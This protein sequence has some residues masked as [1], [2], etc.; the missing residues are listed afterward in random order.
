[1][2][3]D[4]A[5]P[6]AFDMTLTNVPSSMG[7]SFS[8]LPVRPAGGAWSSVRDFAKFVRLELAKGRLPDGSTYFPEEI[9]LERRKPQVRVREE[10]WY[11]MGLWIK[12][13][14]GI[15]V[16][17]HGG[18]LF[19]YQSDFF[20]VPELGLGGVVLT[21]ADTGYFVADAVKKR[22]L[23]MVYDGKPEAEEDLIADIAETKTALL[24]EQKDWKVPPNASAVQ[25]LEAKYESP[26]LGKIEVVRDEERL[27]FNLDAFRSEMATKLNPDG[28]TSFITIDPAIRGLELAAPAGDQKISTLTLR[29][30]QHVYSFE[31]VE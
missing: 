24:G 25:R 27:F 2:K 30:P 22:V 14:K 5:S 11:G 12:N 26:V 23:E 15:E 1:M 31:A 16:I 18:A 28:S 29:D 10:S 17:S 3:G 9:L 4:F 6:H 19:G 7:M 13:L 20:F 8:V 21:N